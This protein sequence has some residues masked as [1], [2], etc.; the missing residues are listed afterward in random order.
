[1][2]ERDRHHH[3]ITKIFKGA[4]DWLY[5]RLTWLDGGVALGFWRRVPITHNNPGRRW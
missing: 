5:S 2:A 4:R 3:S 1:M